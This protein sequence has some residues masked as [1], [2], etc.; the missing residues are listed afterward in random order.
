MKEAFVKKLEAQ[1]SEW[2]GAIAALATKTDNDVH[3]LLENWKTKRDVAVKK[4]E[5]LKSDGSGR[6]DILKMGV[7]SAWDELRAA[8]ETATAKNGTRTKTT[9][10]Q[11]SG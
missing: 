7:E 2:E 3:A 6:W 8:F 10:S 1:L 4:L 11:R 5:E 9:T